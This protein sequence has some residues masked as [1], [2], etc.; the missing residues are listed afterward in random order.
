MRKIGTFSLLQSTL[1][2]TAIEEAHFLRR[3]FKMWHMI[4]GVN[5]AQH[6]SSRVRNY[7]LSVRSLHSDLTRAHKPLIAFICINYTT[8]PPLR[9]SAPHSD[10]KNQTLRLSRKAASNRFVS[11]RLPVREWHHKLNE[12]A[13]PPSSCTLHHGD[14]DQNKPRTEELVT[15]GALELNALQ[16]QL[17]T[18]V[19]V[20]YH[21]SC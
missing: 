10:D 7:T 11:E 1:R 9:A 13:D 6:S 2:S 3:C 12:S 18:P 14:N 17:E 19:Q 21:C 16:R 8:T 5:L 4:K 20:I 15:D